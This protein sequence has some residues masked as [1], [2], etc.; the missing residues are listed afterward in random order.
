MDAVLPILLT[1][2]QHSGA[3]CA[4]VPWYSWLRL[5]LAVIALGNM[6]VGRSYATH[7]R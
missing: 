3:V 4:L 5:L 1:K 6:V 2:Q 7:K